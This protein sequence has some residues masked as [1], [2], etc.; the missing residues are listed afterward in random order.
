VQ[1]EIDAAIA[2]HAIW[3]VRLS[4]AIKGGQLP[5]LAM[6][7][8]DNQCD[9]GKWLQRSPA[10]RAPEA[11]VVKKLHAE[12]HQA[13]AGVLTLVQQG[14]LAAAEQSIAMGGE[15]STASAKLTK[16]MMDWKKTG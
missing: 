7:R 2:A 10:I 1:N 3:K 14:S 6:T 11:Q 15:F 8:A 12:F 5:D 4:S 16:A 13:A 9:F